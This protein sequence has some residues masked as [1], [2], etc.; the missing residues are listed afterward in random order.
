MCRHHWSRGVRGHAP[1]EN[2]TSYIAA[3]AFLGHFKAYFEEN[4]YILCS[5][6]QYEKKTFL[7]KVIQT[8]HTQIKPKQKNEN[9][10]SKACILTVFETIWNSREIDGNNV[11]KA[12]ILV[13]FETIWKNIL[14]AMNLNGTSCR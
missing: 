2:L 13:V 5:V 7:F 11:S 1:S 10:V 6:C 12:C 3:A 14:R 9:D 4:K 8:L